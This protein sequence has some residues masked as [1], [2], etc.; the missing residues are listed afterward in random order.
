MAAA[1]DP[2][3][4]ECR[5][6]GQLHAAWRHEFGAHTGRCGADARRTVRSQV[7]RRCKVLRGSAGFYKVLHGSTRFVQDSTGF[8]VVL[9]GSTRFYGVLRASTGFYRVLQGSTRFDEV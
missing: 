6:G 7:I 5:G 4:R 3:V 2:E 8:Y 9:Q 1:R